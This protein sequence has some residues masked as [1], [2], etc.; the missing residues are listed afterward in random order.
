VRALVIGRARPKFAEWLVPVP[1][2]A[3]SATS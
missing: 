1:I 3:A 2:S